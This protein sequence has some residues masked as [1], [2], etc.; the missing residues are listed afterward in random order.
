VTTYNGNPV[1][2][3]PAERP[4]R[5]RGRIPP[6]IRTGG[7]SMG[8]PQ[9][10]DPFDREVDK[11]I[12]RAWR[13]V[14]DY[15]WVRGSTGRDVLTDV[16]VV[17]HP[18][19]RDHLDHEHNQGLS[20]V[21]QCAPDGAGRVPINIVAEMAVRAADPW[22]SWRTCTER[23]PPHLRGRRVPRHLTM[24]ERDGDPTAIE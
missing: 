12:P 6:V 23:D 20:R 14:R 10:P 11:A 24:E 8:N 16:G 2:S 22:H 5:H 9:L 18:V 21:W 3:P 4:A 17:P 19:Y 7:I 1:L 15:K 13:P